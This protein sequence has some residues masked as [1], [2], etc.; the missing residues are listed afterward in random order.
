[1]PDPRVLLLNAWLALT[2]ALPWRLRRA[3][4]WSI[5]AGLWLSG[6]RS[7]RT[8]R[9]NIELC[10]PERDARERLRLARSSLWH[11]ALLACELG[12]AWRGSARRWQRRLLAIEGLEHLEREERSGRGVVVL[13]P[14]LGN[15]EV[16]GQFVAARRGGIALYREARQSALAAAALAGRARTGARL[17][18]TTRSGVAQLLRYLK[19]GETLFVLPDQQPDESGGVFADFFGIPAFTQ[20]LIG[21]LLRRTGSG[22]V[23]GVCERRHNGFVIRFDAVGPAVADADPVAAA[24][25]LNAAIEIAVRRAPEQYQWE[26]RRFSHRPPGAP[27]LYGAS[28]PSSAK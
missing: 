3:L 7:A 12:M 25:A 2:G 8:T 27:R 21:A 9:R 16:L 22:C 17:V 6:A 14:H 13:V 11:T 1:M 4:A 20:T 24:T 28:L 26:Y 18:P 5:S 19:A 10:F 23:L 15:W